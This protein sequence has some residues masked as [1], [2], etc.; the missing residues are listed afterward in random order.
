MSVFDGDLE[1]KYNAGGAG[2]YTRASHV[3]NQNGHPVT[4]YTWTKL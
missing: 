4:I 2:T 3:E 1:T